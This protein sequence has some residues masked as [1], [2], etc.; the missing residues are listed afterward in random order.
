[1]LTSA[2]FAGDPLL[3]AIADDRPLEGGGGPPARISRTQHDADPA[4]GKVQAALLVWDPASLPEHGADG[5]YRDETAAAVVRFKIEELGVAP[6]NVLDDVGP[7]TVR[8]LDEILAA[9]PAAHPPA[10]DPALLQ[11]LR[12]ALT[13]PQSA[14]VRTLL[15][16]LAAAGQQ[17]TPA[18]LTGVMTALLSP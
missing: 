7:R 11:A 15:L 4:V 1:M 6:E 14:T 16:E 12:A 13:D 18:A 3:E 2:L 17:V 8:R 5:L 10:I 9:Q